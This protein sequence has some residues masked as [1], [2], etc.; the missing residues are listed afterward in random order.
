MNIWW[1]RKHSPQRQ[2][3][4]CVLIL[5][6]QLQDCVG[7]YKW[8]EVILTRCNWVRSLGSN[9]FCWYCSMNKWSLENWLIRRR[10]RSAILFILYSDLVV[11]FLRTWYNSF[12]RY[13]FLN[14]SFLTLP[15]M[16]QIHI[17][18]VSLLQL[19]M[20]FEQGGGLLELLCF[21]LLFLLFDV[22]LALQEAKIKWSATNYLFALECLWRVILQFHLLLSFKFWFMDGKMASWALL[23]CSKPSSINLK[24]FSSKPVLLHQLHNVFHTCSQNIGFNFCKTCQID[25]WGFLS[26][27]FHILRPPK[28]DSSL[29]DRN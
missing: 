12:A 9:Y 14:D 28:L 13:F 25:M 19:Q 27:L 11:S 16:L 20:G 5:T 22:S 8:F 21:I 2:S 26:Q 1:Q 7:A 10:G 24:L 15:V 23:A 18:F 17:K 4:I 3:W 6:L 29:N